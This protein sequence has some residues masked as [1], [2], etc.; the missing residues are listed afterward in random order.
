MSDNKRTMQQLLE[1]TRYLNVDLNSQQIQSVDKMKNQ[2][3]E[4]G[5][6]HTLDI[7]NFKS[8]KGKHVIGPFSRFTAI[9]GPNGSG[10]S[11]LM[12]AISFV[13]G[14]RASS[15]RVKKLSDLIHGAPINKPVS[16][17]CYVTMNY[18]YVDGHMKAFT[19][20]VHNGTS[21]FR[22]DG[23]NVTV[24]QYNQEMESINIFIK[25][26]N[27]LV[28]QGAIESIA[29]KNPKERTQLFE[30][31][32]RSQ[33]FQHEYE[34]LKLEMTKAED[35]TQTNMNKRRGIAQEKRE[36]KMEKDE[37]EKYQKMKDSV[38]EKQKL[39]YL[40]Q[41]FHVERIISTA[42]KELDERK[43]EI[44]GL[45]I[46]K[47]SEDMKLSKAQ[48]D[49]K[50]AQKEYHKIDKKIADKEKEITHQRPLAVQAKVEVQHHA[51][52]LE[53]AKK[54]LE[55]AQA[56]AENSKKTLDDLV[57]RKTVVENEKKV[58][59]LEI[60]EMSQQQDLNLS[61]EQ[62]NEYNDLK[63]QAI[64]ESGRID[65]ELISARQVL[66][67]ER[68]NLNHEERRRIEHEQR[69]NTKSSEVDRVEKQ[70]NKELIDIQRKLSEASGDSAEGERNL[71]RNE[72][73]DNLRRVFPD[74]IF[75]RL[76]DLCQPSH[77]RFQL[78]ITKILQKHM[79]S[80]VCDTEE[81][82]KDAIA[83]LKE[84]RYQPETFLPA[85][86]LDVQPIS[87]KL[88]DLKKPAGVKL[89]FDVI[90]VSNQAARK[91]LQFACGNA[92]LCEHQED[93]KQL[94]YG[95]SILPD[96]YKAVAMDGTL[97]QQSGVM[98]GGSADLRQKAK[99]W[100]D[101]VVR[102]L[103]ETKN[104]L[105]EEIT[106]LSKNRRKELDVEVERNKI[107][108]IEHRLVHMQNE[109][110]RLENDV[111]AR[112]NNELEG[113]KAE[114]DML[115]PRIAD[116]QE[117]VKKAEDVVKDLE[118]KNNAVADKI[119]AQFCAKIGIRN[120]REYE[121]REL[122]IR[123]ETE[124]KL[125]EFEDE[126]QK[127]K[128]EI[129]YVQSEDGGKKVK[130]EK[131]KVSRLEKEFKELKKREKTEETTLANLESSFE[132]EKEKLAEKKE[133]VQKLE[134]EVNELKKAALAVARDVS[135]AEK[136]LI[137][138][139][140]IVTRKQYERHSLLHSAKINQI[141]LPLLVGSMADI[142]YDD[143]DDD[144]DD[145]E[146][147]QS[148]SQDGPSVSQ[149]QI[150]RE[151]HIKVNY[152]ILPDDFQSIEDEDNVKKATDRLNKEISEQQ[153]MISRLNAPNLKA[154]QR[155]EEVKE[156]EAESTEELENA[157]RKAKKIRQQFERI[158]TERY[159]RFQEFFDPVSNAID[160]IY[161]QLSRNS[162]AQA[163]LGADN[164][165]E[166][167]LDG[168][169]YNCVAPGKRFRPMDN[170]SGGEKTIAA[171]ALLFAVHGRNPAPFF[172]LDEIDAALDNTNIGKVASYICET[173]RE[174][175]QII[176]ISLKEEFYNK[177]D[178]L[179]G[180]YQQPAACTT[181]G[182]LTF[183]L[184]KFKQSGINEMTENVPPPPQA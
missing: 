128:Y 178:A 62:V 86:T 147:S 145:D 157:R 1:I 150:Q 130:A 143:D 63:R 10:K 36:A 77:K 138:L 175:M 64:M 120:I 76:V 122:R 87:E 92:L 52:K 79:M 4:K 167:Y 47:N 101:K 176:V 133:I 89:V 112:L 68:S 131:E 33:E 125:R 160:D 166:P 124:D 82:A 102:G 149:E 164:M 146:P 184:T 14:E 139:E 118:Q 85:D 53:T 154:N 90:N 135:A 18:K 84:Q 27:F 54:M 6:L 153:A 165:E 98:S 156:R 159:R 174:E 5:M 179:V 127:L 170:L 80:I 108:E 40:H 9:I 72:A 8:Y 137:G 46:R 22:I 141:P 117:R 45:E 119:F 100:D 13:L 35:D 91:A 61:N 23:K 69:V 43:T 7:E 60:A 93:A 37:A 106:N 70:L 169:Q 20:G 65:F 180:I 152:A 39:L 129:D 25:A 49:L 104:K 75:G 31:L 32:S 11:N 26:K 58:Y 17:S 121:D 172:V 3:I 48:S 105:I 59:E 103:R 181:S 148:S 110:R 41:L 29:M 116:L 67:T 73:I 44:G 28:Y 132:D 21:E 34:R 177:A 55:T 161:K 142:D 155:M 151:S 158:K 162:S 95:G 114:L 78:A 50:K 109:V 12:D 71:K 171:L 96:R 51:K 19:R 38:A 99:K 183:D 30:E 107:A 115:P 81:T 66:E 126:I 42:K 163:F 16:K 113:Y 144:Y 83:Y 136:A 24:Q 140:G 123:Q 2:T 74:R 111:L 94:A 168:I 134:I 56:M 182:V 97:F 57:Q 15:L 173:A 88:R